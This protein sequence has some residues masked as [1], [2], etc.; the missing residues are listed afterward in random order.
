WVGFAPF[1]FWSEWNR[2]SPRLS[3]TGLTR[4]LALGM[5]A[6]AA[7]LLAIWPVTWLVVG[8]AVVWLQSRAKK[9]RVELEGS[10]ATSLSHAPIDREPAI[11]PLSFD[12][13]IGWPA[14]Y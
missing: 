4:D 10:A 5:F 13:E 14:R 11:Q 9:L 12:E 8:A 6:T 7:F 2:L 1:I 3:D